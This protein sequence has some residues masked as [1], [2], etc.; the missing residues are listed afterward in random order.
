MGLSAQGSEFS[1][2][3]EVRIA[4][5]DQEEKFTDGHAKREKQWQNSTL[6]VHD[7]LHCPL[8]YSDLE[9]LKINRSKSSHR[10]AEVLL[11]FGEVSAA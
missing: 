11:D 2:F 5:R 4:S 6:F 1:F 10:G 7:E 3:E 9:R 8:E